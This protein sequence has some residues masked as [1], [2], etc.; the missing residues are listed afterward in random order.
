[1]AVWICYPLKYG[2]FYHLGIGSWRLIHNC[3][4][5][6]RLGVLSQLWVFLGRALRLVYWLGY[7]AVGVLRRDIL[8][9]IN[10]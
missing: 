10:C 2:L 9:V 3:L 1:M 6:Y 4:K 7:G 5:A 8:R